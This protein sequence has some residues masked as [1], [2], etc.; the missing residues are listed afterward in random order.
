MGTRP[1][2]PRV[3]D[4]KTTGTLSILD[5]YIWIYTKLNQI[6]R[7]RFPNHMKDLSLESWK[8]PSNEV[9]RWADYSVS[10]ETKEKVLLIPFL[11][12]IQGPNNVSFKTSMNFV[13]ACSHSKE[14]A[15]THDITVFLSQSVAKW[16]T[17]MQTTITITF[18]SRRKITTGWPG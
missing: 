3:S 15:L 11:S 10:F 1:Q 2:R 8:S 13:T 7:F 14:K 18:R 16:V 17:G 12:P 9:K 6:D 5:L 4:W